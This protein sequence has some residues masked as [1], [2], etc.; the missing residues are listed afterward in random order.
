MTKSTEQ[1][2]WVAGGAAV[3]YWLFFKVPPA[4]TN[5]NYNNYAANPCMGGQ[6]FGVKCP[7]NWC[8]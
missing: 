2:L 3:L 1:M 7:T 4:S 8:S 6:N 5:P